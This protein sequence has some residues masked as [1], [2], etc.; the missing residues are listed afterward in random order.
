MTQKNLA[1]KGFSL[2]ELLIALMIIGVI[3]TL[4]FKGYQ[5]YADR[6][7]YTKAYDD[8]KQISMGLEQYYL[9]NGSY[10]DLASWE[11]MVDSNSPMV[12]KNY[13][14]V[15]MPVNDP[16]KQPY[17]GNSGK[18]KYTLKCAGDPS[19]QE[20]RPP[21]IYREGGNIQGGPAG[22]GKGDTKTAAP[23]PAG[24]APK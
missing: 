10:P 15:G 2:M 5:R 21:I 9:A 16:W 11:A 1:Q 6:A 20:E 7:R 18:G 23:A 14:S 3:A 8:I 13:I 12:K 4:G 19:D 22:A 24:E 17:E